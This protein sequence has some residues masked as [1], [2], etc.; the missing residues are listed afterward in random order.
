MRSEAIYQ[1]VSSAGRSAILFPDFPSDL[2]KFGV[3]GCEVGAGL[4]PNLKK[5]PESASV[6]QT[7]LTVPDLMKLKLPSLIECC[8]NSKLARKVLRIF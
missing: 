1:S 4:E 7:F 3:S 6:H 2:E 5:E 8:N